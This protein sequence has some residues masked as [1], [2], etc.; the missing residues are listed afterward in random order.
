MSL[1]EEEDRVVVAVLAA[2]V[3]DGTRCRPGS[4]DMCI[5]GRCQV[6]FLSSVSPH[7]FCIEATP[8]YYRIV[9]WKQLFSYNISL[10][11]RV[12]IDVYY[13]HDI[14]IDES[15][16]KVSTFYDVDDEGVTCS[17]L[18]F[19]FWSRCNNYLRKSFRSYERY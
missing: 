8:Q 2:R 10:S 19:F 18:F 5:D 11:V 6:S 12:F 13:F 7:L 17:L 9:S 1:D 14:D 15:G 3:S 4:L 16:S